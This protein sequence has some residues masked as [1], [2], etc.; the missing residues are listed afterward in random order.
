LA[1]VPYDIFAAPEIAISYVVILKYGA[2]YH[3][4]KRRL[5]ACISLTQ[6][7]EI[8]SSVEKRNVGINEEIHRLP[9]LFRRNN[10][11]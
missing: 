11:C 4:S 10:S 9:S 1:I 6:N 8:L 7:L 5:Y 2:A 3:I